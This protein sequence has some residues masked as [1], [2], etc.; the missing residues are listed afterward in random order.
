MRG[1]TKGMALPSRVDLMAF[2][3]RPLS[4]VVGSPPSAVRSKKLCGHLHSDGS[5]YIC[6]A[7][8]ALEHLTGQMPLTIFRAQR[9][10]NGHSGAQRASF[11]RTQS[12]LG[13]PPFTRA[14][15]QQRDVFYAFFFVHSGQP[16][17]DS[18]RWQFM[19]KKFSLSTDCV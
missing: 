4:P 14:L 12:L 3:D 19:A 10:C 18:N 17:K 1:H 15:L 7:A 8:N 2:M 5:V 16:L 9:L 11:C 13:A 6:T